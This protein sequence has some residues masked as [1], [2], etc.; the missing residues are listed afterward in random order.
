MAKK[1][2]D[3]NGLLYYDSKIKARL[4]NKVDKEHKTNSESEYKVLRISTKN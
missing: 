3:D 1:F 4:A 2:L